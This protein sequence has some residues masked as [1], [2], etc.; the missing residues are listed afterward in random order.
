MDQEL[1]SVVIPTF[2][3]AGSVIHAIDSVLA[4]THHA[5]EVVVV[6][7]GSTDD[8]GAR[9][10]QRYRGDERV[11][12]IRQ[13]NKGVS[14]ARN[15]GLAATRG[16]YIALLDSDDLWKPW[17]LEVQLACLRAVPEAGMIWTDMKAVGPDGEI[18]DPHYLRTMYGATYRWFSEEALFEASRPLTEVCPHFVS[19]EPDRRL[20]WGDI[21]SQMVM[22]NMVHTSTVLLRRERLE[23]VG[24]FSEALQFSGEDYDFHLRTCREGP[25]AFIDVSSIRYQIG[26]TDQLTHR[27]YAIH[28]AR[29]FLATIKPILAKD[30]DR[31]RLPAYMLAALQAY[32]Y[33]WIGL[34]YFELGDYESARSHLRQSLDFQHWQP[35]IWAL[36]TLALLPA[37]SGGRIV[38]MLR[39]VKR[40][41]R[42]LAQRQQTPAA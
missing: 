6:D 35:K 20:Y 37:G 1:V 2:N 11:R 22:G 27:K 16:Q 21:F 36:Y 9:I 26:R 38:G 24:G 42:S 8:T 23:R 29:N 12:Y 18:L 41:M 30:S 33:G 5:V 4:Q 28:I 10:A 40:R 17:K 13:P 31:I 15:T 19:P 7:D 3:R 25:V 39:T 14:A 32:A 34:E